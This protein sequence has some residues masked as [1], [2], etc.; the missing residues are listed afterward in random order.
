MD[1]QGPEV[2]I[3][4]TAAQIFDKYQALARDAILGHLALHALGAEAGIV[5][6]P[7][8]GALQLMLPAFR[9]G[10]GGRIGARTRVE[11]ARRRGRTLGP[12]AL[13]PIGLIAV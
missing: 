6:S 4:G 3:R 10:L 12:V 5:L 9:L 2:K 13:R 7:A 1:S 11:A 8:G